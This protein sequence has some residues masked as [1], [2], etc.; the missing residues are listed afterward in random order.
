MD[1]D[2]KFV[3][4]DM[5]TTGLIPNKGVPLELGFIITDV[6]LKE[7]DRIDWLIYERAWDD[8]KKYE[9][10]EVEQ[11]VLDM[12]A[13]SGIWQAFE[14][15]DGVPLKQVQVDAWKWL[16]EHGVGTADPMCG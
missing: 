4:I 5:E 2:L 3:F 12:H 16:V 11:F 7:I 10:P 14:N 9:A 1:D 6:N 15:G 8:R 13:K